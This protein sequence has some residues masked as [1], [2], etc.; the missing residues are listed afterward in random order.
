MVSIKNKL[1]EVLKHGVVY[2]LTASLQSILGF[3]LLPILTSF[4][5]TEEFGVY[6]I[7]LVMGAF[8]SSIF[9]LGA[10]SALGRFYY[11]EN[12]EK[13][14]KIIVS[15]AFQITLAGALLLIILATI[16]AP[17][18]SILVFKSKIYSLQVQLTFYGVA[19]TFL[20]NLLTLILRYDN[21]ST[22]FMII[23]IIGVV[24][25]FIVTYTLLTRYSLGITAPLTGS[26]VSSFISFILLL[27]YIEG[28]LTFKVEK[29]YLIIL[30]EFGIPALFTGLLYYV[31][32]L[33]DRFIIKDLLGFAEVGVYSLGYK[34]A[35]VINV[36]VI[37]P[38]CL[39]WAPFRMQNSKNEEQ[40]KT[41]MIKVTSYMFIIGFLI[42]L[43]AIL[44]SRILMSIFFKK[45]EFLEATTIIPILIMGILFFGLQNILDYGIN[46]H[47]KL[48]Y[49]II[50]SLCGVTFNIIANYTF[51]PI[52]GYKA[53]AYVTM[54]TYVLT[55]AL[56]F[57]FSSKFFKVHLE[58]AR[59][60]VP[61]VFL[62]FLMSIFE[63][64]PSI[65]D[66]F[67]LTITIF[68]STMCGI[69]R[70]WLKNDE[71][72]YLKSFLHLKAG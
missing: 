51:I 27:F 52:F 23:T 38:F 37:V 16:F 3:A 61:F 67:F 29:K 11:E 35:S 55:T 39:I 21:K 64:F 62:V 45:L 58:W 69:Y 40:T 32:D 54:F 17:Y 4:Y 42:I 19:F 33:V 1:T 44:Y 8:A 31:L 70:F 24:L 30:L 2:G 43:A 56:I 28:Y 63:F 22:L 59:I 7:L 53:A 15:S 50:T 6:S 20:L 12:T 25:N 36:L 66:N 72:R 68:L 34:I 49:Y 65:F 71:R 41:L 47:K 10:S 13:Y 26:L 5:T 46:L 18:I 48:Q 9:Y 14:K 60:I 57:I